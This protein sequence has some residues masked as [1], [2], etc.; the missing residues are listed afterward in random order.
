MKIVIVLGLPASGKSFFAKHLAHDIG[1]VYLNTDIVR[2]KMHK[3]GQY[4][5]ETN[6]LI[7][8][9]MLFD[10][11]G[12]IRRKHDV[13]ADGTFQTNAM[14][15]WFKNSIEETGNRMH[16]IEIAASEKT[17]RNRIDENREHS[18]ADFDVYLKIKKKYEPIRQKHM[19]LYSDKMDVDEM[20]KKAKMYLYG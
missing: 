1:A 19:V 4:D 2:E 16:F 20:I 14:R 8:K 12:N 7:Y 10:M 3:K 11:I 18:E 6:L 5:N 17:I 15:D 13:I 9:H